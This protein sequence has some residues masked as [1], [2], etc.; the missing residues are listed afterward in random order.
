[1]VLADDSYLIREALQ[2][3][4]GPLDAV[5]LIGSYADGDALLDESVPGKRQRIDNPATN[6][7]IVLNG[8]NRWRGHT[9]P[10][11]FGN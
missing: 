8:Q 5:D 6:R 11:R 2:E 9:W 7:G 1:M 10:S 4:L 3:V